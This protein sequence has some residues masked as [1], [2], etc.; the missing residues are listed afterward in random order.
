[1]IRHDA[2]SKQDTQKYHVQYMFDMTQL[3]IRSVDYTNLIYINSHA[4]M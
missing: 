1:M 2:N 3:G 4:T